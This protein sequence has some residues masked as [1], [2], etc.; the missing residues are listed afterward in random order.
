MEVHHRPNPCWKNSAFRSTCGGNYRNGVAASEACPTSLIYRQ[1]QKPCRSC[2]SLPQVRECWDR[3][4]QKQSSQCASI[5]RIFQ[6]IPNKL[7]NCGTFLYHLNF[8]WLLYFYFI[9]L[10]RNST[11]VLI[12]DLCGSKCI[13]LVQVLYSIPSCANLFLSQRITH[14]EETDLYSTIGCFPHNNGNTIEL[15]FSQTLDVCVCGFFR[16]FASV[17]M[18]NCKIY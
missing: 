8:S 16:S 6:I 10:S 3:R 5:L 11:N 9:L 15:Q 17:L 4:R 14:T 2:R 12:K 7:S 1:N 18:W 13:F